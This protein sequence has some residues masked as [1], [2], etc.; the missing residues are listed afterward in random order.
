MSH[1]IHIASKYLAGTKYQTCDLS[2]ILVR[3]KVYPREE[4]NLWLCNVDDVYLTP[5]KVESGD[6]QLKRQWL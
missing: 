2:D 6:T 5:V 3:T 4:L 1:T